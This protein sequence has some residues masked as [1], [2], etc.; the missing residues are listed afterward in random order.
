MKTRTAIRVD[1]VS[2]GAAQRSALR[3]TEQLRDLLRQ[4]EGLDAELR[5]LTSSPPEMP[6]QPP[7]V[8]TSATPRLVRI[9]AVT[10]RVGVSRSTIWKMVSEGR[11]P[12]PHRLGPRSVAWLISDVES[13]IRSRPTSR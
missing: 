3:L 6:E 4:A 7:I 8:N 2:F 12:A 11:F 10:D 1:A 13:W 9:D 5:E